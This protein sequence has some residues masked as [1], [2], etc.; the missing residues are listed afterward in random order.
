VKI[1]D[2]NCL[3]VGRGAAEYGIDE[4][5]W[6]KTSYSLGNGECIEVAD[7]LTGRVA[8]RDSK[9]PTGSVLVCSADEWN[10]FLTKIKI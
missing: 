3:Q 5:G 1:T 10:F 4:G 2:C 9:N 6:R 7:G 8:V